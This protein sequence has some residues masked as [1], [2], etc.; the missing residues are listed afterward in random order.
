MSH[1]ECQTALP[2]YKII[3]RRCVPPSS[4]LVVLLMSRAS[5]CCGDAP[6]YDVV[7]G[8]AKISLSY[9]ICPAFG[10]IYKKATRPYSLLCIEAL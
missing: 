7:K 5:L 4:P 10:Q 9:R 3:L 2:L 1:G 8:S 6:S